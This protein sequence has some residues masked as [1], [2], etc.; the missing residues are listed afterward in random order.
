MFDPCQPASSDDISVKENFR[1]S[2]L[3]YVVLSIE[4]QTANASIMWNFIKNW[5]VIW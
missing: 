1:D 2:C 3:F 5:N 4:Q